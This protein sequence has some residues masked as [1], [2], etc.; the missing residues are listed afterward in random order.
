MKIGLF[1]GSFNPI[2]IGHLL[3]ATYM[4]E[5]ANF[6]EVWF[7]VSPQN[8][9][10]D[11]KTLAKEEHRY[12]MVEMAIS[13]HLYFKVS[14]I[15]FHLP[16]P[17]YTIDTLSELKN[18]FKE[19]TFSLILGEDN[20]ENLHKWK[21]YEEIIKNNHIYI[22]NRKTAHDYTDKWQHPHF[23]YIKLPFLDISSTEI[24]SRI[25][26]QLVIKYMVLESVEKYINEHHLYQ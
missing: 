24:R 4:K 15:E 5:K 9:L 10:K 2:H 7:I 8:P 6:D 1:P 23:H 21:N 13:Q 11:V 17:S 25:E 16:K 18:T 26:G 22:Y 3:L 20:L 19:H 14:D 12:K